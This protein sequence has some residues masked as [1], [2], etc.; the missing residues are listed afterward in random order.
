MKIEGP[1][2]ARQAAQTKKK[3]SVSSGDGSFGDMVTGAAKD[4]PETSS[5]QSVARIDSL[6]SIQAAEDPAQGAARRRMKTRA[7]DILDELEKIRV[8]ILSGTLT[9]GQVIAVADIVASHREK[10]MDPR[11]TAILDEIDLRAQVE[12][13]KMRR[14]LDKVVLS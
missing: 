10:I 13:A 7:G 8:R 2:K 9:V 1:D 6:L 12:I 5:L 14:A 4:A 11:L 3:G